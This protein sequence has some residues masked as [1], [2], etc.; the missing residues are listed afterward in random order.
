ML[1]IY[2]VHPLST[3]KAIAATVYRII[4]FCS[5]LRTPVENNG[6]VASK[7]TA[8]ELVHFL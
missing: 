2:E 7:Q 5:N 8:R 3:I 4:D 1:K 6:K